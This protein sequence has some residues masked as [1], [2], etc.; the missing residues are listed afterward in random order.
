MRVLAIFAALAAGPALAL[1]PLPECAEGV[2]GRTVGAYTVAWRGNGF[3]FYAD[4]LG[5]YRLFLDDC[6]GDRRL[7][8]RAASTDV[9]AEDMLYHT[10]ITALEAPESHSMRQIGAMVRKLGGKTTLGKA[11][12]ESCGCRLHYGG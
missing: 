9:A 8:M 5:G 2:D 12:Y 7:V 1:T 3:V 4:W 10:V 6:N 11:T